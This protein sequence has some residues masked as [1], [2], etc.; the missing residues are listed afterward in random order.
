M[1]KAIMPIMI[2]DNIS[3]LNSYRTLCPELSSL[4]R[5]CPLDI[6]CFDE[7]AVDKEHFALFLVD[8][9]GYLASTTWRENPYSREAVAALRLSSGQF[10]L[11][12]PGEPYL[13]RELVPGNP[14]F[15]L[16]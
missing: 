15:Y 11:F 14:R 5:R 10:V 4:E 12:L 16:L 3:R 6:S 13:L 9:G 2:L 1:T 8:G 7:Y